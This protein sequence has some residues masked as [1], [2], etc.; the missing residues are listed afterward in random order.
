M[1]LSFLSSFQNALLKTHSLQNRSS[2]DT[3]RVSVQF[4]S[5]AAFGNDSVTIPTPGNLFSVLEIALTNPQ[6]YLDE[7]TEV[8]PESNIF[9]S[10]TA[11]NY[12]FP[13]F[14][15]TELVP[16]EPT[17]PTDT[18]VLVTIASSA[19]RKPNPSVAILVAMVASCMTVALWHE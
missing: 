16:Q 11:I 4:I 7:L 5:L 17:P 14:L 9:D 8:L 19:F 1:H 12:D 3:S 15:A 6:S 2:S 10:T 18:D 13:Q